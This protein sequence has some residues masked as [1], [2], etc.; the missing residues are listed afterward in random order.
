MQTKNTLPAQC[1]CIKQPHQ[2]APDEYIFDHQGSCYIFS[3]STRDANLYCGNS[4]Y[5]IIFSAVLPLDTI[6]AEKGSPAWQEA[7]WQMA[8]AHCESIGGK[9]AVISSPAENAF[10]YGLMYSHAL[11]EAYFGLTDRASEGRWQ[12]EGGA[13]VGYVNWH[14]NEPNGGQFENYAMYYGG[15]TDATW[16]DA[17]LNNEFHFICEWVE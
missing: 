13:P 9:L 7:A 2:A 10:L 3:S 12:W 5:A 17:V 14:E 1:K 15:F 11:W 8:K 16:N 4:R 6:Q